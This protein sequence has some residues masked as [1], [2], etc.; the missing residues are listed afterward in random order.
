M[1]ISENNTEIDDQISKFTEDLIKRSSNLNQR[2]IDFA[3][4]HFDE[5]QMAEKGNT[6]CDKCKKSEKQLQ[7]EW[8]LQQK[9]REVKGL[10]LKERKRPHFVVQEK[11]GRGLHL[12]RNIENRTVMIQFGNVERNCYSCNAIYHKNK[13]SIKSGEEINY[14]SRVSQVKRKKFKDMLNELLVKVEETCYDRII[15]RYSSS[16]VLNC[17]QQMLYNAFKQERG[18]MFDLIQLDEYPNVKCDWHDCTGEHIIRKGFPP[19]QILSDYQAEQK[20]ILEEKID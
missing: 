1:E 17:S 20:E 9:L 14:Q 11:A 15:Q 2:E 4:A 10:P 7:L 5:I 16:G 12:Y 18:T 3:N 13:N 6:Y 8:E 19:V